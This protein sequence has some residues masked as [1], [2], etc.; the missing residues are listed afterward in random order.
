[1][2]WVGR[3]CANVAFIADYLSGL[4]GNLRAPARFESNIAAVKRLGASMSR[5]RL[6]R[7]GGLA[8]AV[9][10]CA[11]LPS[12][13]ESRRDDPGRGSPLEAALRT[14]VETLASDDFEGR[15]PGTEG[16]TKTLRYLARQWFDIGMESGTND[17]GNAWFAPVEMVEREPLTS[18][19][20]FMRGRKKL[21]LPEA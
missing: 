6:R 5:L 21:A 14:H 20:T 2:A 16:E 9:L 10:A 3:R 7:L 18:R 13:A 12:P 1:M 11:A 8:L 4:S 17:P 15:E 19:A